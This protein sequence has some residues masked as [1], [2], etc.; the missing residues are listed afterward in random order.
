MAA[1][2]DDRIAVSSSLGSESDLERAGMIASPAASCTHESRAGYPSRLISNSMDTSLHCSIAN[3]NGYTP[4]N[5][6]W[7]PDFQN[8]NSPRRKPALLR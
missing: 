1:A 2:A 8:P 6:S 4:S 5:P 3:H 7:T